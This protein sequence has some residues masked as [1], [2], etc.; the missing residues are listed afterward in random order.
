MKKFLLLIGASARSQLRWAKEHIYWWLVLGPLVVG[1]TYLTIA[2]VINNLPPLEPSPQTAVLCA[3]LFETVLIA[4]SL[5]RASAEIYHLRRPES[6][7]DALPVDTATHVRAALITR[8]IR[9]SFVSVAAL[10]AHSRASAGSMLDSGNLLPFI[11]FIVVTSLAEVFAALNWIHWGHRKDKLAAFAAVSILF[12][13]VALGAMLLVLIIKPDYVSLTFKLWLVIVSAGWSAAVCL[14]IHRAHN[15]WRASDIEYATRLQ[16]ASRLSAF[17]AQALKRRFSHVVAAQLARDFQLTL[18][19]FSSAVYVVSGISALW[20]IALVV[21]L[22]TNLVSTETNRSGFLD[23]TWLP[24]VMAIKVACALVVATLAAIVP[25]LVAYELPM[26]WVERATGAAGLELWQA[27][28][29]YAR[30]VTSPA[31][32]IIWAVGMLTGK[33]P[34][35]YALPLMAEC[36]MLWWM[37]SSVFGALSF[38]MPQRPGLAIIVIETVVLAAGAFAVMFWPAGLIIYFQAMHSLTDR[39]KHMARVLLMTEGD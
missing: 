1:F 3:A 2:R 27:K 24:Q 14:I 17:N 37:I 7:F 38:E 30:I 31:P 19:A 23:A 33:A 26:M 13:T 22:T 15:R 4:L 36:L 32:L 6:Y 10:L 29:W 28:L 5:S 34:V 25:L 16:S 11:L 18:R 9:T 35:I 8:F 21:A 20:A 12:V 39:G